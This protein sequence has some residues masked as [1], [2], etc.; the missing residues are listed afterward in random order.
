MV[1]WVGCNTFMDS[2]L[3]FTLKRYIKIF[4]AKNPCFLTTS[5]THNISDPEVLEEYYNSTWNDVWFFVPRPSYEPPFHTVICMVWTPPQKLDKFA[6]MAL[7]VCILY[8]YICIKQ[9]SNHFIFCLINCMYCL[10]G[11]K[12]R[13]CNFLIS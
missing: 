4:I 2:K 7:M 12:W 9:L 8:F 11:L 5:E 13:F 10:G 6:N 1:L 3:I